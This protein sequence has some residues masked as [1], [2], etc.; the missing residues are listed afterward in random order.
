M[1]G[2]HLY[3]KPEEA[4]FLSMAVVSMIEQLTNTS[5]NQGINWNPEARGYLRDM[6]AAAATLKIKME[7]LGM[8]MNDLPPF[9]EGDENEFLT[10]ES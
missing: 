3:L 5:K 6:L 9:M 8:P 7:K 1:K 10:K 2:E 4:L